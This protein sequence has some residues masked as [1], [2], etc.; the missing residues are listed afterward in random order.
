MLAAKFLDRD[1][2]IRELLAQDPKLELVQLTRTE[3]TSAA[4][5]LAAVIGK[6]HGPTNGRGDTAQVADGPKI[7]MRRRDFG[8]VSFMV[9]SHEAAYLDHCRDYA[10]KD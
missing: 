1:L 9:A 6:A 10:T 5:H 4:Q 7:S 8:P 3:A 2:F